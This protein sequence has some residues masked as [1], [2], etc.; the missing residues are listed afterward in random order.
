MMHSRDRLLVISPH[1]DDAVLSCGL[2]LSANPS[3]VV[4]TVFTAPPRENMS[5]EWDRKSGFKDAFEAMQARQREDAAALE[6][7]GA[8][9]VHLP[10]CDAQYEQTPLLDELA[11]ALRDTVQVHRPDKVIV[12]LGLF[13][14]DHTL[15]SDACLQLVTQMRDT[16]FHAYEDV[17]YRQMDQ[18]VPQRIE[19][20]TKR[21][22]LLSPAK[23]LP[24]TVSQS[25]SHEQMKREAISAYTSQLRAF[26]PGAET[27]LYSTE[28]YWQL[29]KRQA[30]TQAA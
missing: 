21:G 3:A 6:M 1:L 14:S 16:E 29:T 23:D 28:K 30:E 20:L 17:P 8:Q 19:E 22:Y 25:V 27:T 24:A 7:L 13:H 4:C 18:A 15:V 26:G 11:E 9:P 2:L 5:T 10:F 12:P